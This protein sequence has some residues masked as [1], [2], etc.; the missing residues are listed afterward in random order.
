MNIIIIIRYLFT[1]FNDKYFGERA[2]FIYNNLAERI[3]QN[4]K[5][6]MWEAT[7]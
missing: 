2:N 3:N 7:K 5:N 4:D 6:Y 1:E